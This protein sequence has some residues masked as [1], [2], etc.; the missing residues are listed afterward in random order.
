MNTTG[1]AQTFVYD[2]NLSGPAE[3]PANASPGT[4]FGEV[5]VDLATNVLT[6]QVN[7]SGLTGTTTASHVHA[8]TATPGT[9]TAGVATQTPTFVGFPLGVTAGSYNH[10]FDMTLDSTWNSS[11]ETANGGTAS[12][13]DTAFVQALADGTAYLNIHTQVF[14]GG[15]IRGFLLP[16]PE[17]ATIALLAIGGIGLFYAARKGRRG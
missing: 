4:G 8:P 10:T 6:V 15:E 16:V 7:F 11:Y 9:G 14:P 1:Q 2:A 5:T 13:A 12:G 17:P 3:S